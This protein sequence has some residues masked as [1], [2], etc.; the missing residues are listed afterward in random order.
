MKFSEFVNESKDDKLLVNLRLWYNKYSKLISGFS[1][2]L[3][4]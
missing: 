4:S 1:K 2:Q 3:K